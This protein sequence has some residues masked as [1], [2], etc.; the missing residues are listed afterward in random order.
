[1]DRR[2]SL[3]VKS[4][5]HAKKNMNQ[6][7]NSCKVMSILFLPEDLKLRIF[8]FVPI[9][10]LINSVRYVCKSWAATIASSTFT[11]VYECRAR[12]KPGLYVENRKLRNRSYLLEFK[13][14][15]NGQFERTDLGTPQKMGRVIGTCHGILL[16]LSTDRRYFVVNPIL[17]CWLT[18]PCFPISRPGLVFWGQCTIT[19]VL[20]TAKFKLFHLDVIDDS[21]ASW[22]VFYVLRIGIDSSWKEI[23]RKE[24]SQTS[25]RFWFYFSSRPLYSGGDDLYWLTNGE[26]IVMDI[27][28]EIIVREYSLP[29]G[30][31]LGGPLWMGNCLSCVV[32]IDS[33]RTHQIYILDFDSGEWSLYHEIG[34]FDYMPAFGHSYN[35]NIPI[36]V[37][38]LWINDRIIFRVGLHQNQIGNMFSCKHIHFGYNVKTKQLTKLEDIDEGNFEVWLH[39]NSL[40]SLPTT[41]A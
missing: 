28:K 2:R 11:Q 40:V 1:M 6:N 4:H 24:A 19:H 14:D 5:D 22:F 38:C 33:T 32:T 25:P 8:H 39:T 36:V 16:L 3:R 12:S 34:P 9:H 41:P 26:V 29:A 15:V 20:R 23:A 30:K 31:M 17:K 13:D 18:V 21:G 35:F 37:F 7:S 10:C 27:D